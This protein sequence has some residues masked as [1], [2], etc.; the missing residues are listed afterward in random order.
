M[1]EFDI[2]QSLRV[3]KNCGEK[4][5]IEDVFCSNCG[6]ELQ[7]IENKVL[8]QELKEVSKKVIYCHTCG[9]KYPFDTI[10]KKCLECK[11]KLYFSPPPTRI[12]IKK[13][14]I[15]CSTC[16]NKYPFDTIHKQCLHCKTKLFF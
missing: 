7:S 14:V 12:K 3:C 1:K 11:T 8:P 9:N 16:G 4:L 5:L 6:K 15:I 13:N 10:H 2:E